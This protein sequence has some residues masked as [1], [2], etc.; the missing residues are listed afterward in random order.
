MLQRL[1]ARAMIGANI[2]KG[3]D[4]K[5]WKKFSHYFITLETVLTLYGLRNTENLRIS[6]Q[7]LFWKEFRD[8]G[9]LQRIIRSL[10]LI[11]Q[12]IEVSPGLS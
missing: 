4:Q 6:P 11:H 5:E 12:Q 3:L 10:G 1:E 2:R 8:G 7:G 9:L